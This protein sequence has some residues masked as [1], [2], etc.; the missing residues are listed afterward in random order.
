MKKSRLKPGP[1]VTAGVGLE[2]VGVDGAAGDEGDVAELSPDRREEESK[3]VDVQ[4]RRG[5]D[6]FDGVKSSDVLWDAAHE[7][8]R[9]DFA[10]LE[11]E[12]A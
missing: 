8:R 5:D 11:P 3:F 6:K 7:A 10:E 4:L 12:Q 1:F 2:D 9:V